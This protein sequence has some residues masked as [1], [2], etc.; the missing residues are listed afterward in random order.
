MAKSIVCK[1]VFGNQYTVPVDE[2]NIRVGVYAV[3]VEG[4]KILLTRQWDGY[5]LI[6]GGVEKVETI[7]ESIVREVK[8]ETGLTIMPDRIIHQATT[9]FKR[10]AD[11]QAN[12]SIQ[13]YFTHSQLRG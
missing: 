6:G 1:D 8:E 4:N 12:Q 11:S 2:L 13:L 9:F 3:V 7:E 5:S 10:N